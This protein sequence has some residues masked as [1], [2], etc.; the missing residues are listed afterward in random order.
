MNR[1]KM[2][3]YIT[4]CYGSWDLFYRAMLMRK[5][6]RIHNWFICFE[7]YEQSDMYLSSKDP[8]GDDLGDIIACGDCF[9]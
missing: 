3:K 1:T 6:S 9:D 4:V 5:A 7:G 8:R 2:I